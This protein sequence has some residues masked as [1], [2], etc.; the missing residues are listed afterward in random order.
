MKRVHEEAF[1]TLQ[2]REEGL[3]WGWQGSHAL[4]GEGSGQ[5]GYCGNP[6]E[7]GGAAGRAGGDRGASCGGAAGTRGGAGRGPEGAAPRGRGEAGPCAPR[8]SRSGVPAR[9]PT[10][11]VPAATLSPRHAPAART[12]LGAAALRGV[13]GRGAELG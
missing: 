9:V 2:E 10:R 11:P 6:G 7:E 4:D 5:E 3:G 12:V 1:H 13:S 8:R